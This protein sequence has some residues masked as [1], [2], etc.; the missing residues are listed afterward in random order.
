MYLPLRW[1]ASSAW[2]FASFARVVCTFR[3]ENP[4]HPSTY[5]FLPMHQPSLDPGGKSSG[6]ALI[7]PGAKS[8]DNLPWAMEPRATW[9]RM[10]AHTLVVII[11]ESMVGSAF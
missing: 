1:F 6:W 10:F 7:G 4:H 8:S 2:W 11:S 9:I 3:L 5:R